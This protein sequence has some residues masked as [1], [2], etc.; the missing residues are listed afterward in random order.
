MQ[1]E[2]VCKMKV[3]DGIYFGDLVLI[4]GNKLACCIVILVNNGQI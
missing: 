2:V 4:I 3:F 1:E